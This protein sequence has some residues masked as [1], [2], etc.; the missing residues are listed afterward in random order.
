MERSS[1]TG[2]NVTANAPGLSKGRLV[3]VDLEPA[4]GWLVS[5]RR[6]FER[7]PH[8]GVEAEAPAG[9]L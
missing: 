5:N 6:R 9:L 8:A 4:S 3:S 1:D 7:A 2:H